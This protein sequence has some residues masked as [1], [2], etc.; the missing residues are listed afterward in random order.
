MS[1]ESTI[2][3]AFRSEKAVTCYANWCADSLVARRHFA[4]SGVDFRSFQTSVGKMSQRRTSATRSRRRRAATVILQAQSRS[5]LLIGLAS[6][7]QVSSGAAVRR[8]TYRA[9]GSAVSVT[10]ARHTG[11]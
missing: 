6:A 11:Q 3:Q 8:P 4:R 1:V 5:A 2:F 10:L 7:A 9:G